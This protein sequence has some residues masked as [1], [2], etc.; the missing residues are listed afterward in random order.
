[1]SFESPVIGGMLLGMSG[2]MLLSMAGGGMSMVTHNSQAD[3]GVLKTVTKVMPFQLLYA[4][5]VG[6]AVGAAVGS[7]VRNHRTVPQIE[8]A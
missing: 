4:G 8:G 7:A 6:A 5:C 1:M 3:E 2:G